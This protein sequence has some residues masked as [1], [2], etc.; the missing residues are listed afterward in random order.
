MLKSSVFM[1]TEIR[2]NRENAVRKS[3]D[4]IASDPMCAAHPDAAHRPR[5][6]QSDE[7]EPRIALRRS[8]PQG[9]RVHPK[10][11]SVMAFKRRK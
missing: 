2:T 4:H 8:E 10:A 11:N 3:E 6:V 1:H 7:G 9:A 5:P